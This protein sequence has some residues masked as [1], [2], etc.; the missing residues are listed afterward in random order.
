MYPQNINPTITPYGYNQ[1]D[2]YIAS[3]PYQAP[4]TGP[5]G[6]STLFNT[7]IVLALTVICGMALA[8]GLGIA[9]VGVISSSSLINVTNATNS[10]G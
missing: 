5:A 3:T 8:L 7:V 1:I 2:P 9:Q 4:N 6:G 10:T